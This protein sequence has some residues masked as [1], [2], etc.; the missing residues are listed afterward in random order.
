MSSDMRLSG[1]REGEFVHADGSVWYFVVRVRQMVESSTGKR[2]SDAR[3][4]DALLERSVRLIREDSGGEA[5]QSTLRAAFVSDLDD[6]E[7]LLSV[8]AALER[9]S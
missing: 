7:Q 6:V 5:R 1:I 9:E 2:A 3:V 8:C 4:P